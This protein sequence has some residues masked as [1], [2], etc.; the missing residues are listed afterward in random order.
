MINYYKFNLSQ[1][2]FNKLICQANNEIWKFQLT[3]VIQEKNYTNEWFIYL[4]CHIK[5]L[6]VHLNKQNSSLTFQHNNKIFN[7]FNDIIIFPSYLSVK[8][9]NIDLY[10]GCGSPFY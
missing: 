8:L 6:A 10:F 2:D 3:N 4:K 5:L 1:P 7:T 9:S